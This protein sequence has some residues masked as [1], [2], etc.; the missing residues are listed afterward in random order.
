MSKRSLSVD[1][2]SR[3]RVNVTLYNSKIYVHLNE[4]VGI[5][6]I[7]LSQEEFTLLLKK[8]KKILKAIKS[9]ESKKASEPAR[10]KSKKSDAA[11]E[12]PSDMDSESDLSD[13]E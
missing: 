11:D 3:K 4:K 2:G 1:L 8:K 10:K 12:S 13:D 9:L 7:S 6:S 5:K